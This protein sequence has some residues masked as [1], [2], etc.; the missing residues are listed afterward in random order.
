MAERIIDGIPVYLPNREGINS[1]ELRVTPKP[2]KTKDKPF[3]RLNKRQK[4][5]LKELMRLGKRGRDV[6]SPVVQKQAA[7][8]A[9]YSEAYAPMAMDKLLKR[10]PIAKALDK[11]GITDDFIAKVIK[12]GLTKPRNP[13]NPELKDYHAIHK[14]VQ[15][16]NKL[17][18]NYPI[19]KIEQESKVVH[20]HLTADDFNALRRYK[21]LRNGNKE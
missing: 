21:E 20:I 17:K 6:T 4:D 1:K 18:D 8:N 7:I 3:P 5:A 13:K 11:E 9:G 12:E 10:K 14:F 19:P 15:E 16:A 2:R